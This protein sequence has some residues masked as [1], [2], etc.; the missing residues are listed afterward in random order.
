[1]A[2]KKLDYE[3]LLRVPNVDTTVGFD[4]SP[5]GKQVAFSWNKTGQWEIYL[6]DLNEVVEPRC[7]TTGPGGKFGPCFSP[8]GRYLLY[9][10]D[11]DGGEVFDIWL[12][13]LASG[14]HTNLTPDTPFSFSPIVDWSP[15]GRQIAVIHDQ[16]GRFNTYLINL[17]LTGGEIHVGQ[18]QLVSNGSG[19]HIDLRWSPAGNWLAVI[20]EASQQNYA[21]HLVQVGN[22]I[23]DFLTRRVIPL[24]I[25]GQPINSKSICWS[26]EGDRLAFSSDSSGNYQIGVFDLRDQHINWLTSG[27]A[28]CEQPDLSPDGQR[29]IYVI[30]RGPETWLAVQVI[31]S[32]Q[33]ELFQIEPGIHFFPRFTLDGERILY[34]FDSPRR[35]DDL[36]QLDLRDKTQTALTHSL[37]AN[38][39]PENF[40]F[41]RHVCYPSHDGKSVPALLYLPWDAGSGVHGSEFADAGN[42]KP[43]PGGAPPAVIVIHGGPSWLF[44]FLWYP[45]MSHMVSRGWV[46][47]APNYRG[48]TGYGKEWQLANRFEMGR[49]DTM[50]VAAGAD[51]LLREGLADPSRIAIT[52]R[53]HGG[54]LTMSCL[55]RYPELWAAGSAV[56]PF[57]NW[58]TSNKSSRPDLRHWDIENMGDPV[59]NKDLWQ[60]CSP[61]FYLD[62]IMAPVQLICGANDPRCPASESTAARDQL[63]ALG[64][65]VDLL[66]YLDEGHTFLKTENI[67]EHE[68]K[69]VQFLASALEKQKKGNWDDKFQ[70]CFTRGN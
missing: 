70:C 36:W 52:G 11:L 54:F 58:F 38:L 53:S 5:D 25:E 23:Q 8:D 66:L 21:V 13:D 65:T 12:C 69:R 20:S 7:L 43:A 17:D 51:Y 49:S 45:I 55:T 14:R 16:E 64:K 50:D 2:L 24:A 44:Q 28:D 68:L 47:L 22:G 34:I 41:P 26:P 46:V 63:L 37:P 31:G 30:S 67:V 3:T 33:P 27:D 40:V 62:R 56:V 61:Y 10:L 32:Q 48:S 29:L 39:K 19:P 59:E 18:P 42:N 35:P 6:L 1:M 4:I 57:L 60:E 9:A 15:D